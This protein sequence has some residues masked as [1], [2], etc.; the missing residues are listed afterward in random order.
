M[1]VSASIF[2]A[3][4]SVR[5]SESMRQNGDA[6]GGQLLHQLRI[7]RR[8]DEADQGAAFADQTDFFRTWSAHL[9]DDIGRGPQVGGALHD[10]RTGGAVGIVAEVGVVTGA[11][12][13]ADGKA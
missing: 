12:F 13:D 7:L 3:R 6:L 4:D 8:P 9:E 1:E 11:G 5:G 10:L 2:C